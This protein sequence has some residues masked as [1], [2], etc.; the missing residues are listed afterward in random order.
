MHIDW[1][2]P[3]WAIEE[4]AAAFRLKKDTAR[5]YTYLESFPRPVTGFAKNLWPRDEVLEWFAALP[6][7][8]RGRGEGEA[9]KG[10]TS[11]AT[12]A[13]TAPRPTD[14]RPGGRS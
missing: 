8:P 2:A 3:I 1:S 6:R 9:A 4:I 5:E 10:T 12:V 13:R 7:K 11:T 14:T